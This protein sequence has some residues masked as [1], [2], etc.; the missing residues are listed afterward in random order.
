MPLEIKHDG[1]LSEAQVSQH[2]PRFFDVME[3]LVAV[4]ND[5]HAEEVRVETIANA[6]MNLHVQ[7]IA[8]LAPTDQQTVEIATMFAKA[9]MKLRDNSPDP[10]SV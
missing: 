7:A 9:V 10:V 1:W 4:I 8:A 2:D 5:F 6:L 3:K